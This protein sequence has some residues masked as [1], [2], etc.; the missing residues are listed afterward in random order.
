MKVQGAVLLITLFAAFEAFAQQTTNAPSTSAVISV[1]PPIFHWLAPVETNK[2]AVIPKPVEGLDPRAWTTV[3]GWHP[4]E[5]AFTTGETAR[6]GIPLF[7]IAL[8]RSPT[9]QQVRPADQH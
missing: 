2:S 1:K 8:G 4:G 6:P 3:V 7:W 9:S 5:S